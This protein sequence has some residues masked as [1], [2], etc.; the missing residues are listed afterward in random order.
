MQTRYT[1]RVNKFLQTV[2]ALYDKTHWFT[3]KE[4]WTIFRIFAFSE[5][6]GWTCLIVGVVYHTNQLP[7]N[8]SVLM[9]AGRIHGML[10]IAYF[11]IALLSAR[12]MKWGLGRIIP[13]LIAGVMPYGSLIFEQMIAYGRRKNPVFVEPPVGYD[14]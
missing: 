13:A 14:E 1:K 10:F 11:V 2:I 12:S 5:A 8:S 3:D 4:A 9:I 6:V 7:L